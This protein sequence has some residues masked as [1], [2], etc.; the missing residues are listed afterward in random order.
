MNVYTTEG[1]LTATPCISNKSIEAELG[2]SNVAVG[3]RAPAWRLYS[4]RDPV[5]TAQHIIQLA[6]LCAKL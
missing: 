2:V 4:E 3:V 5:S 6:T 1:E